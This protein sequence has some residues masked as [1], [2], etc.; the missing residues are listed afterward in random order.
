MSDEQLKRKTVQKLREVKRNPERYLTPLEGYSFYKVDIDDEHVA[1]VEW[2]E[3][4]NE[5]RVLAID[6]RENFHTSTVV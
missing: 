1:I 6:R 3:P 4:K 2:I 5:I